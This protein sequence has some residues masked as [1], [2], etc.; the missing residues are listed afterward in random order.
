MPAVPGAKRAQAP[1]IRHWKLPSWPTILKLLTTH[2]PLPLLHGREVLLSNRPHSYSR[3]AHTDLGGFAS[4]DFPSQIV[5]Q[6]HSPLRDIQ[7]DHSLI[8]MESYTL[9]HLRCYFPASRRVMWVTHC[10]AGPPSSV[11][12]AP[13]TKHRSIDQLKFMAQFGLRSQARPRG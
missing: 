8:H 11:L 12:R 6:I 13:W 7:Q 2:P 1:W 9:L 4:S 3:V 10:M 5:D